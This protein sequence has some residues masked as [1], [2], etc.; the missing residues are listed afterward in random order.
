MSPTAAVAVAA[1]LQYQLAILSE[2]TQTHTVS[3][4][5]YQTEELK[6]IT[7]KDHR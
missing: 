4:H 1:G 7:S 5:T 3:V 6:V 2:G